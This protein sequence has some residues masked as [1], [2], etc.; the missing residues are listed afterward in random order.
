MRR[1]FG[2]NTPNSARTSSAIFRPSRQNTVAFRPSRN[3]WPSIGAMKRDSRRSRN[4]RKPTE[5]RLYLSAAAIVLAVTCMTCAWQEGRV[6]EAAHR[7]REHD[8]L[9]T[10]CRENNTILQERYDSLARESD[11]LTTVSAEAKYQGANP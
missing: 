2:R 10:A 9:L 11:W 1:S 8:A 5:T 7:Q 6:Y 3:G 4:M